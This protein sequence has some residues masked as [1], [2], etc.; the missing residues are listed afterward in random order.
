[1]GRPQPASG[2]SWH[3]VPPQAARAQYRNNTEQKQKHCWFCVSFIKEWGRLSHRPSCSPPLVFGWGT[4]EDPP[5]HLVQEWCGHGWLNQVSTLTAQQD[6]PEGSSSHDGCRVS[7][8][9]PAGVWAGSLSVLRGCPV[10]GRGVGR[11]L[12]LCPLDASSA[13]PVGAVRNVSRC[14]Q[15]APRGQGSPGREHSLRL[16]RVYPRAPRGRGEHPDKACSADKS[17]GREC[18]WAPGRVCCV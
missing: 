1:M 5:H 6:P 14:R 11:I 3:A 16:T 17:R 7:Q 10:L 9:R 2:G 4:S 12:G 8:P 13:P 15:M 18:Q